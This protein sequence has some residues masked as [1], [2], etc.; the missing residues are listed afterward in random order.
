[1]DDDLRQVF[2]DLIDGLVGYCSEGFN[3]DRFWRPGTLERCEALRDDV[4]IKRS[5]PDW[6]T[7]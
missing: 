1:M 2:L 5:T 4:V 6:L 7:K 3:P